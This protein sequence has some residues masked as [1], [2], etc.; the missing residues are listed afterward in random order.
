VLRGNNRL[1]SYSIAVGLPRYAT[2]LGD[3]ALTQITWNPWWHPP[4]GD[5][6]RNEKITEPGPANPWERDLLP[7]RDLLDL[8]PL[9][10]T[11]WS[12]VIGLSIV[13]GL[14]GQATKYRV[15]TTGAGANPD[16]GQTIRQ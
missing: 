16:A 4:K 13:P 15:T 5:W 12:M 7:L 10:L 8:V 2:P 9:S 14:I 3:F 11:E 1:T 6:A